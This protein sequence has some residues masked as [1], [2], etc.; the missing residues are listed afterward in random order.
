MHDGGKEIVLLEKAMYF[1]RAF[2][3]NAY[4]IKFRDNKLP[5]RSFEAMG[6]IRDFFDL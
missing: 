1:D 2:I 5:V 6:D 4:W 3:T